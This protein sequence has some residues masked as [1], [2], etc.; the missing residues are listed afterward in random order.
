MTK[1][2]LTNKEAQKTPKAKLEI[3]RSRMET[4]NRL[5]AVESVLSPFW[6]LRCGVRPAESKNIFIIMAVL[7]GAT[8]IGPSRLLASEGRRSVYDQPAAIA[9]PTPTA[10]AYHLGV[11]ASL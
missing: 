10:D 4:L 7:V 3:N 9:A 5:S 1:E 8:F 11:A 6:S 2:S